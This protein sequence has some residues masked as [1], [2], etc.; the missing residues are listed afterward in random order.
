MSKSAA[1][2][3]KLDQSIYAAVSKTELIHIVDKPTYIKIPKTPDHCKHVIIWN[4]NILPIMNISLWIK[5]ES[6]HYDSNVVAIIA[7]GDSDGDAQ[8]GGIKLFDAPTLEYVN[9]QQMSEL[10][11]DFNKWNAISL[12][13]FINKDNVK[14]PILDISKLFSRQLNEHSI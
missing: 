12:S 5:N 13:C 3:M 14:V 6:T 4:K 8:Y 10:P 11:S 7:Y 9:N 1:W 2:V